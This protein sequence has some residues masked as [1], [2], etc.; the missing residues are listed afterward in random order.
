MKFNIILLFY[1]LVSSLK[2]WL[3]VILKNDYTLEHYVYLQE[4]Y[5]FI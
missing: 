3:S 4:H 5:F 2:L 1:R